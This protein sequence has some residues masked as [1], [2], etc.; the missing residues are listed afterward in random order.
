MGPQEL[1][2]DSRRFSWQCNELSNLADTDAISAYCDGR[3]F[4]RKVESGKRSVDNVR[5]IMDYGGDK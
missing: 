4:R 3:L 1:P 2:T 5:K